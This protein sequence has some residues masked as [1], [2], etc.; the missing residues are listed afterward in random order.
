MKAVGIVAEYNPLHNGHIYHIDQAKSTAGA[1]AVVVAMSGDYVQRGEPAFCDKWARTE[2]ALRA[3]A[4]LAV[5]IPVLY[6]LGNAGQYAAGGVYALESLGKTSHIAFGSES[7]DAELLKSVAA[8]LSEHD[9]EIS[10]AA[11][12]MRNK[13]I[14]YPAAREKAYADL[15]AGD[16]GVSTDD[17]SL[18]SELE[19]LRNPN[20]ILALEYIMAMKSA[21]PLAVKRAGAGYNDG[22]TS[23]MEFQ[24]AGAIRKAYL[25]GEDI[26]GYVPEYTMEMLADTHVTGTALDGWWDTLRYAVMSASPDEIDECPSGG[27]GL[28]N[29][30][31]K[32]IAGAS[33]WDD[34]A[35][36]VKS[37]RYTYTRISRLCM[38]LI[39]GIRRDMFREGGAGYVRVLGFNDT[40][41]KLLGEIRDEECNTAPVIININK[42][43]DAL[44][45]DAKKILGL[46]VHAADIYNMTTGRSIA[47]G[48]DH[49]R[50][51]VMVLAK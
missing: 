23:G 27:E 3:G 22:L 11:A 50:S 14:S 25:E 4:D 1:D 51:P 30:F 16:A 44:D 17:Q 19:I 2:L 42:E 48:S 33:S 6:C 35:G 34:F 47:D 37:K 31:K 8:F 12:G 45:E 29:L 26:S 7:A 28:G 32:E 40:G 38:Q 20:D 18:A 10:E 21:R 46:D 15:R 39:L 13:G 5:E 41:R 49:R 36:R 9:A 43:T 24:S